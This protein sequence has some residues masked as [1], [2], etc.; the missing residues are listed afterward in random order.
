MASLKPDAA[1]GLYPSVPPVRLSRIK[2]PE[3]KKEKHTFS[4]GNRQYISYR[5]QNSSGREITIEYEMLSQTELDVFVNFYDLHA[6]SE[7]FNLPADIYLFEPYR[8]GISSGNT[9]NTLWRIKDPLEFDT[10]VANQSRGRFN[11][12]VTIV[13][14]D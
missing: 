13:Q 10:V 5:R 14:F 3:Y 2:H 1:K 8:Q 6:T 4:D 12:T 11:M 7:T 9:I